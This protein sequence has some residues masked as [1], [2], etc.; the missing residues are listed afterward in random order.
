MGEFQHSTFNIEQPT[1]CD[2]VTSRFGQHSLRRALQ[3]TGQARRS[4]TGAGKFKE[5]RFGGAGKFHWMAT[6]MKPD[7][8]GVQGVIRQNEPG[9]LFIGQAIFDQRQ[10]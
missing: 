5:P 1:I 3:P 6:P 9:A 2:E 7:G 4:L 8:A 10:I